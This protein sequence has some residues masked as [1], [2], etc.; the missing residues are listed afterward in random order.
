MKDYTLFF[1]RGHDYCLQA[2]VIWLK[3]RTKLVKFLLTPQPIRQLQKAISLIDD[4][5]ERLQELKAFFIEYAKK[6]KS[7]DE[8]LSSLKIDLP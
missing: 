7:I 5:I 1:S 3:R 8:F 6:Q 4:L 2:Y